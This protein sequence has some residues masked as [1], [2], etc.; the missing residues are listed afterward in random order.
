MKE[1]LDKQLVETYPKIFA[2]RYKS[3]Q[4][5]C[6]C[7]GFECQSG[8]FNLIDSLCKQIQHY[9]DQQVINSPFRKKKSK[10]IEQVVADQVKEKYGTL[11]FYYSGGDEYIRGLVDMVESL[12]YSICESCGNSGKFIND[13][14][15]KVRCD[16]CLQSEKD[17]VNSLKQAKLDLKIEENE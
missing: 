9:L 16:K 8:W 17:Y 5:T 11:C 4:E 6:M 12:S 7:W 3:M 14:W 1:E 10:Q 15:C 2:N 13:G